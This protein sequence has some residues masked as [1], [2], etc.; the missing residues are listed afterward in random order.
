MNYSPFNNQSLFW[1]TDP[2]KID[3]EKN[4]EYIIAR[5]LESGTIDDIHWLRK[6]YTD[7]E[8]SEVIINTGSISKK[9]A[10]FWKYILNIKQ[11]I[12]CLSDQYQ[13]I[14]KAHWMP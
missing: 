14:Q 7:E 6:N 11:E 4:K 13:R 2:N 9:T 8:I 1:D 12:R 3:K 10:T 5:I